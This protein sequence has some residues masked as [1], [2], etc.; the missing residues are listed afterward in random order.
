M[1]EAGFYKF[2]EASR[3]EVGNSISREKDINPAT[4]EA[5][6]GAINEFKQSFR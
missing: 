4:E 3:P 2:M 6:K 1:V 5:L